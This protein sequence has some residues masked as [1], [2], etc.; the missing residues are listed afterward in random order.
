M[1]FLLDLCP[2][3]SVEGEPANLLELRRNLQKEVCLRIV[4]Y[5]RIALRTVFALIF[6]I[7]VSGLARAD[8][9]LTSDA[10]GTLEFQ[11]KKPSQTLIV[12]YSGD[13]GLWGDLDVQLARRL[14][15]EGYAVVGIDTRK[16]FEKERKPGEIAA[17]LADIMRRYMRTAQAKRVVLMGYSFGADIIPVAYNRLAPEWRD[18]VAAMVLL[19]PSRRTMF[20]VTLAERTG[21]AQGDFNLIPEYARLPAEELICIYGKEEAADTGCTLPQL[22]KATNIALPGGHHFDNDF[23]RLGDHVVAALKPKVAP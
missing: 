8:V 23:K 20:E 5:H 12:I 22:A 7:L 1:N 6:L 2:S 13:G 16:W 14:S 19:I 3:S 18:V 21:L 11:V 10:E 15:S 9:G 17:H 4:S